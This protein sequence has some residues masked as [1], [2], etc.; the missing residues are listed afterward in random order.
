MSLHKSIS[1]PRRKERRGLCPFEHKPPAVSV[2]Y[3]SAFYNFLGTITDTIYDSNSRY[4]VRCFHILCHV[5]GSFHLL[6]DKFKAAL[7]LLV[8]ICQIH[9]QFTAKAQ[10][11]EAGW[12]IFFDIISMHSSPAANGVLSSGKRMSGV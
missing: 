9:P 2:I 6:D 3:Q 11:I 8:Q 1:R 7:Y 4:L 10:V 5:L 12:I